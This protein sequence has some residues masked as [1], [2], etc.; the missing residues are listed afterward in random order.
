MSCGIFILLSCAL[1][2]RP[3]FPGCSRPSA[4]PSAISRETQHD[5][6]EWLSLD[7][8]PP[9]PV[10]T[11]A[12]CTSHDTRGT[13]SASLSRSVRLRHYLLALS[14]PFT[15]L[16]PGRQQCAEPTAESSQRCNADHLF[17]AFSASVS[18]SQ[19]VSRESD[20][21]RQCVANPNPHSRGHGKV[22]ARSS[23]CRTR[24]THLSPLCASER[25]T[26]SSSPPTSPQVIPA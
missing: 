10:A 14:I 11:I 15:L 24:T 19:P 7:V 9:A 21:S 1:W 6:P 12:E 23:A 17:P 3:Q 16:L 2:N 25:S 26:A 4:S 18:R 8:C 20:E 22:M 5:A 13:Y